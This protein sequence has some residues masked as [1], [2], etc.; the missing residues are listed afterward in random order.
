MILQTKFEPKI[1]SANRIYKFAACTEDTDDVSTKPLA[2]AE[3]G[4]LDAQLSAAPV[5]ALGVVADGVVTSETNPVRDGAV[6][7]GG[8][9]QDLLGLEALVAWHDW[10]SCWCSAC[11]ARQLT[12]CEILAQVYC[13]KRML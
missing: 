13:V 4:S 8:L 6:L 1:Y 11:S 9:G 5:T 3:P 2:R 7:A 10:K 12:T